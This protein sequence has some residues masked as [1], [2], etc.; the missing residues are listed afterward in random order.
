MYIK[1]CNSS[2]NKYYAYMKKCNM[3]MKIIFIKDI[4]YTERSWLKRYNIT[5][6]LL[7][8]SFRRS[9]ETKTKIDNGF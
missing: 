9:I 1:I 6:V 8:N 3:F 2:W 4:F 7:Y 5:K